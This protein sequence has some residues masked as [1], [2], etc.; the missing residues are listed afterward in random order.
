MIDV[1]YPLGKSAAGWKH[2]VIKYSLRSICQYAEESGWRVFV[3]GESPGV[4]DYKKVIH[5]PFKE[6][7]AKEINIM[8]K[9]VAA[10]K[11]ERVSEEFFW[12]SDDKFFLSPFSLSKYPFYHKGDIRDIKVRNGYDRMVSATADRLEEVGRTTFHFDSHVPKRLLKSWVTAAYEHFK[13]P[14]YE[15][16]G[17]AVCTTVLNYAGVEGAY[18]KDIKVQARDLDW[19]RKNRGSVDVFSVFDNAQTAEFKAFMD[20]LYPEKC[21]FEV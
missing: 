20:E 16:R 1:V 8:E 18:K 19:I 21:Y 14:I 9:M 15:Q 6:T 4:L 11:D 13:R 5:I 12:C 2:D 10:A 17:M 3:I 7:Q